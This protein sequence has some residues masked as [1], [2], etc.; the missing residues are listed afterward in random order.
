MSET[1]KKVNFNI[2]AF[3]CYILSVAF[4]WVCYFVYAYLPSSDEFTNSIEYSGRE[5]VYAFGS[6]FVAGILSV[7]AFALMAFLFRKYFYE[8]TLSGGKFGKLDIKEAT[9]E[10]I[11]LISSVLV[12]AI[13]VVNTVL[14]YLYFSECLNMPGGYPFLAPTDNTIFKTY[15]YAIL[16]NTIAH[17][18]I[19]VLAVIKMSGLKLPVG[20]KKPA[21]AEETE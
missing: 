17:T 10:W 4:A 14:S 12:T 11:C 5:T 7:I 21:E 13:L 1:A 8:L 16:G 2:G 18:V 19:F 3:L 20:K 15:E 9:A 6:S